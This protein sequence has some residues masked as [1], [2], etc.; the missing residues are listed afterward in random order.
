M[1]AYMFGVY[2]RARHKN[3]VGYIHTRGCSVKP[4]DRN[5]HS[6]IIITSVTL[7]MYLSSVTACTQQTKLTY[8]MHRE[9]FEIL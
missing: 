9:K 5:I 4:L 3:F 2:L 1:H 7:D 8:K 6:I